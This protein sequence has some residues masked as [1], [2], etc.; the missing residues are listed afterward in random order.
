MKIKT[1][2]FF[3][4]LL[5]LMIF[6]TTVFGALA[7]SLAFVNGQDEYLAGQIARF[8]FYTPAPGPAMLT[9]EDGQGNTL[10]MI[11]ENF[12]AKSGNNNIEWPLSID[13][14]PLDPGTYV[15][16]VALGTDN[17]TQEIS[18]VDGAPLVLSEQGQDTVTSSTPADGQEAHQQ[19]NDVT[20]PSAHPADLTGY[21]LIP[22]EASLPKYAPSDYSPYDC[23]HENCFWKL[24][25]GEMNEQAI[26]D[27][28]MQPI[29]VVKATRDTAADRQSFYIYEQPDEDATPIADVTAVSQGLH[30]LKTLDNGWS[31]VEG[32]SSSFHKSKIKNY[33]GFFQG[34]IK[35]SRLETKQPS[36]KY[37]L[38]IDKLT[39]KMYVLE[40]GKIIS[41][42]L[43]S[44]GLPNNKQ[45][46]NETPAGDYL[47]VSWTG[48]FYSGNMY[49]D[50]ALRINAGILLH[51][52][53]C[54]FN[55]DGSRNYAPF[56]PLLGSKASHGCIRIQRALT[57]EN[58]NMRWLWD[59]LKMNT[60]V[61]IWEDKGRLREIPAAD[62]P[63][64]Y[65]PDGGKNY[66]GDAYCSNVR[67][68]YLPLSPFTYGQLNEEPYHSLTPCTNCNPPMRREK[69][70]ALN[71]Q[72]ALVVHDGAEKPLATITSDTRVY[73][74]PDGGMYYH[75]EE[76]CPTVN[77]KYLPLTALLYSQLDEEL[78]SSLA[79]C[80]N[81]LPPQ[82]NL[83]I[84]E[85]AK[86]KQAAALQN[87]LSEGEVNSSAATGEEETGDSSQGGEIT[88]N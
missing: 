66:H 7:T 39:Q 85:A 9:L 60:R 69:I 53:P 19:N 8:T 80:A 65:N 5:V 73:Y 2:K 83:E 54:L 49:C 13:D 41:E 30:V 18:I 14:S 26:W 40:D 25:M 78:F 31:L 29:T 10:A 59:N 20:L 43:I 34:Y 3:L 24:P 76:N 28:M 84:V 75:R 51:E 79:P 38:L 57:P 52:V 46:Y 55:A 56:E 88:F 71:A 32:Y 12:P 36:D 27:A 62:T 22:S 86:A 58:T 68:K 33:A 50:M 1:K 35:T 21:Q 44:T 6:S 82:R 81:C 42:L 87:P 64:Y 37:G 23:E 16:K 4:F 45:P 47:V 74:N 77:K 72:N 70:E 11:E 61:F 63:L 67:D 17:A 48:G 15:L